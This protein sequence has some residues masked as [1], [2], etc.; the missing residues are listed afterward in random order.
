MTFTETAIPG[1]FLVRIERFADERGSFGRI[2]C[3]EE[4]AAHGL[5]PRLV[6]SSVS[7]NHRRGTVRGMHYQAPPHAEG[8]LIR[9]TAGALVDVMIDLRP[10]SPAF[11][12]TVSAE[13][14]PENDTML[15]LP[16]GCAHGF[17]TLA[18]RTEIVYQMT[19]PY[20]PDAARGF[21]WDDPRTKVAWPLPVSVISE[22]DRTYPDLRLED[23]EVFRGRP[24]AS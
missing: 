19:V 16:A 11:L 5:D 12:R 14:T 17:Q 20:A 23:L 24:G 3:A 8:K 10:D 13:L 15:F 2:W 7:F 1:G 6:Q 4:F 9:C 18:D 21:R 22:R